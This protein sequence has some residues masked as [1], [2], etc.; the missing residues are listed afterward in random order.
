MTLSDRQGHSPTEGH[1]NA[2]FVQLCSR[3][4][5]FYWERVARSLCDSWASW[6][7]RG[8]AEVRR[9]TEQNKNGF[10]QEAYM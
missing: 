6:H 1:L 4:Q 10:V 8:T 9:R 7:L 3:F 2:I 5:Y